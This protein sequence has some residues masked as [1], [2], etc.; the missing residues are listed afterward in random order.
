[1]KKIL[2]LLIVIGACADSNQ[3]SLPL[4]DSAAR[5]QLAAL[6]IADA[7]VDGAAYA[8][9]DGS[10]TKIGSVTKDDAGATDATLR[11]NHV[12][13]LVD[14]DTRSLS[15]NGVGISLA[16]S[17]SLSD[18]DVAAIAPCRDALR[19]ASLL[20]HGADAAP[21]ADSNALVDCQTYEI[22]GCVDWNEANGCVT[23]QWCSVL[24][25]DNGGGNYWCTYRTSW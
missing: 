12:T 6:G 22:D 13:T 23:Y 9:Y 10:G 15:C 2:G 21:P 3:P 20:Y 19:A 4:P 8:L 14:D 18:A 17:G 24:T 11:A 1:M 16:A 7:K 25:C 5:T